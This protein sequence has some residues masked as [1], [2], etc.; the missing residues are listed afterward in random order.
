[1]PDHDSAPL[2]FDAQCELCAADRMTEW[3]YEDDLCWVAE[4]ESCGTPM[5]VWRSHDPSPPD[6][7]KTMLWQRLAEATAEH[8]TYAHRVDDNMRTIPGHYHAHARPVDG[9]YGHGQRRR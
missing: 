1:M 6:D 8:F 7:V 9:F 5:V 3:F 2:P 4:C